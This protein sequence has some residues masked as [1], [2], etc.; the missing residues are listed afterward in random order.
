MF[1]IKFYSDEGYRQV[2]KEADS[3]TILR[4]NDGTGEAEI[5]L[6]RK[7]PAEDMR[8][9]IKHRLDGAP[10]GELW[11]ERFAK[12]IIEN[13]SGRTT[14]IIALNPLGPAHMGREPDSKDFPRD[15]N[16]AGLR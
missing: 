16:R 3:F 6:H 15:Q 14:E 2:I 12:A 8:I 1:T 4:C 10:V 13:G 9:D 5:T 11:P 7:N